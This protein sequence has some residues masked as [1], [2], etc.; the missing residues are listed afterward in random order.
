MAA[1]YAADCDGSCVQA[2]EGYKK[3]GKLLIH[4]IHCAEFFVVIYNFSTLINAIKYKAKN[5][6]LFLIFHNFILI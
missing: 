5:I 6:F 4:G 1:L 3:Q 2:V